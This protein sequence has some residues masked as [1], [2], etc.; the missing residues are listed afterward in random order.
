VPP[1]TPPMPC[2][3]FKTRHCLAR[4]LRREEGE[5]HVVEMAIQSD[6]QIDIT[7]CAMVSAPHL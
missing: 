4:L 2:T 6:A 5:R 7:S 3:S 1:K